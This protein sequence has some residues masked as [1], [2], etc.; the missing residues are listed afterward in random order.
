MFAICG[1][2]HEYIFAVAT[3]DV[4]GCQIAYF[5]MQGVASAATVR[6]APRSC[7]AAIAVIATLGFNTLA[8]T[9]FFASANAVIPLYQ[10]PPAWLAR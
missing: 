7:W 1:P 3:A 5:M 10:D 4:R 2:M 6:L 9:L 8:A